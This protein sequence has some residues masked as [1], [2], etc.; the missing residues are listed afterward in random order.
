MIPST[1]NQNL[2]DFQLSIERI[3]QHF[4]LYGSI[5]SLAVS[6]IDNSRHVFIVFED[7]Q[8][9]RTA[10]AISTHQIDQK[11]VNVYL[12]E[13]HSAFINIDLSLLPEHHES[14]KHLLN[15]LPD[16][17]LMHIFGFLEVKDLSN[18]ADTCAKFRTIAKCIFEEQFS[19]M[20]Y[21]P[22]IDEMDSRT[23]ARFLRNF[24]AYLEK[25][26]LNCSKTVFGTEQRYLELFCRHCAI[27]EGSLR[28]LTIKNFSHEHKMKFLQPIQSIISRL[29]TLKT[30][31]C[32]GLNCDGFGIKSSGRRRNS[33]KKIS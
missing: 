30:S 10:A 7:A 11:L 17:L 22:T 6:F 25:F 20:S 32:D 13:R 16:E 18:A 23:L 28:E 3:H 4:S 21:E 27:P 1:W 12:N 29:K 31:N 14:P 2:F 5:N 9:A 8:S 26:V 15:R 24:G 19:V 33:K